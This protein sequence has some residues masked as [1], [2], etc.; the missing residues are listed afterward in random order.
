[1]AGLELTYSDEACWSALSD[2]ELLKAM[3]RFEG[4]LA[5]AS[6]SAGLLARGHADVIE[7]VCATA[8]FEALRIAREARGA[9]TLAVPFLEQLRRQV[10]AASPEAAAALHKGAT[11]QDVVDS[12]VVLCMKAAAQRLLS[13]SQGTGNALAGLA[14][15]HAM[16]PCVARTLLQPALPVTFGWKAAV[17][18]SGLARCHAAFRAASAA[19]CVLQFGGPEGTLRSFGDKAEAVEAALARELGL[20]V[21]ATPWHSTRD[22]VARVGCEAAMLA[23]AAGKI[24]RDVSLLMQPEVGELSEPSVPGRGGSSSMAHKRNPSG[25]LLALEAS[26]RT[27][28]LAAILLGQLTP[29]LDRGLGQWQSQWMTL[30]ELLAAAGSALAAMQEVLQGLQVHPQAMHAHLQRAGS[31]AGARGGAGARMIERSLA[32]WQEALSAP[33]T[34][35]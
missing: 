25:S 24:A 16:T 2:E 34:S 6:A 7:R 9:G 22:L 30:R 18:L 33:G 15:K 5:R 26:M 28:G 35:P 17:W 31:D 19:T 27:P 32:A 23:G 10:E 29:E 13:L 4:A 1:M 14:T 12:A 11:T 20:A 3:A 8:Q 21:P